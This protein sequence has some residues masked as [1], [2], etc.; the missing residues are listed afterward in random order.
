MDARHWRF[1]PL[2]RRGANDAD[3]TGRQRTCE[4]D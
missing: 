2:I 4:G 3:D 1:L